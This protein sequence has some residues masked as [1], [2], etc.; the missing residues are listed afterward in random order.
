[1]ERK[2]KRNNNKE[3]NNNKHNETLILHSLEE[4]LKKNKKNC[5]LHPKLRVWQVQYM[6]FYKLD[7]FNLRIFLL[8][9]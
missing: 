6:A 3:E 2:S 8:E 9:F 7:F 1:M 5:F 4:K